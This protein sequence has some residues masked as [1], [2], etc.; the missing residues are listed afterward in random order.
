MDEF[1]YGRKP[2]LEALQ[3]EQFAINKIFIAEDAH[4]SVIE[5]I[6]SEARSRQIPFKFVPVDKL[7]RFFE[8]S[9]SHQ[10][11]VGQTAAA[12]YAD[13]TDVI[14][15]K[16][17]GQP[18]VVLLDSLQDVHNLGAVIRTAEAAA[19]NG[20]VIPK[21]GA[22]GLSATVFKTSAGAVSRLPVARQNLQNALEQL[23]AAGFWSVGLSTQAK[24]SLYDVKLHDLP[25]ALLI[26]AEE[27]DLSP[28][29]QKKC[30]FLL[31]IPIWGQTNSLNASNAAAIAIYEIRR[32]QMLQLGTK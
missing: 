22:A 26:G 24:Q 31:K 19:A 20:V 29:L 28:V 2:L 11:V 5:A 9:V 3:A 21:H 10:G 4:G 27:K 23:K 7:N 1:I 14:S 8:T 12:E 17:V 13:L 16:R 32:Q 30:D 6:K 18:L 15:N 25:I